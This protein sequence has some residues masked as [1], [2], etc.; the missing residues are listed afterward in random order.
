M[1]ERCQKVFMSVVADTPPRAPSD[2]SVT[3]T[4]RDE[5]RARIRGKELA[6]K[7]ITD[8]KVVK[9][10]LACRGKYRIVTKGAACH[11]RACC[12]GSC[13]V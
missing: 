2:S 11:G 9:N 12:E 1:T 3:A 6:N 4:R 5:L 8:A 7:A 13:A 10:S